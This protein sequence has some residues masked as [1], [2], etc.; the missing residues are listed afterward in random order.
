MNSWKSVLKADPTPW[1]LEKE[2]PGVRRLALTRLLDRPASDPEIKE[3]GRD[4]MRLGPVPKILAGQNADGSWEKPDD[5]YAAK[6]KGTSWRLILLA[7]LEADGRD[8]RIR[9]ACEFVLKNSQDPASGGFAYHSSGRSGGGRVSEVIPC[10]TGN[11]VW[12]LIRLGLADDPRVKRGIEWIVRYQRFDDRLAVAP[13]GWPYDRWQTC[14]GR[15]TCHMG[16]VK[17]LKA[18]AALPAAKR[19]PEIR[20]CIDRGAEYFLIHH[21]H[22]KSHNLSAVSKPGWL[23]L[24][25]PWMYQTDILEILGLLTRLGYQDDRMRE[26][27]DLL[28]SK[29]D[30]RGTWTLENTFNGRYPANIEEKEKPSK[31]VTVHALGALK[32]FFS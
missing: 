2:N 3:A 19:T 28:I 21:I 12:S 31:W 20:K 16:A 18:L 9:Q 30:A 4:I 1:L 6:Y 11:M 14:W 26:A 29:Q 17:S 22:K 5:F 10:L 7:E 27:I 13:T 23:R 32:R 24:G 8:Q 15:H 25:F